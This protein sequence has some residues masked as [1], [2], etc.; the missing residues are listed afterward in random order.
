MPII[1]LENPLA[2][3]NFEVT[4]CQETSHHHI[5]IV[6]ALNVHNMSTKPTD[7][8]TCSISIQKDTN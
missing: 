8:L 1:L 4:F 5:A 6:H 7:T 2:T 3:L